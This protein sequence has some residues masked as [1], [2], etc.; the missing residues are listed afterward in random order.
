[1]LGSKGN[2]FDYDNFGAKKRELSNTGTTEQG[3]IAPHFFPKEENIFQRYEISS[4]LK[5]IVLNYLPLKTTGTSIS[6]DSLN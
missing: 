4:S 1:M 3:A 2:T 6:D 5:S